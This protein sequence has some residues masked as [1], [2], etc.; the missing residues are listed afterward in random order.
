[1]KRLGILIVVVAGLLATAT[2][3]NA[4]RIQADA[5]RL[6]G[7]ARRYPQSPAAS[8]SAMNQPSTSSPSSYMLTYSG[9]QGTVT[10]CHIH[11]AQPERERQH[12]HLALP[13][14]H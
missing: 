5:D 9:L 6:R 13:D 4:E 8:S 1:M 3:A 11:I 10:Q 2:M 14:G 7:S 12:R